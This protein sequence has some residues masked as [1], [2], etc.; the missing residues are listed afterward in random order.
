MFFYA[1]KKFNN[2][3][4]FNASVIE[5]DESGGMPW[6]LRLTY[7]SEKGERAFGFG[8][9]YTR[10]ELTGA[11]IPIF[12]REKGTGRGLEPITFLDNLATPGEGGS[13]DF[14]YSNVP[15]Y[16]TNRAR[17][18]RLNTFYPSTFDL[19]KLPP[20]GPHY[21][22]K[23]ENVPVFVTVNT[24]LPIEGSIFYGQNPLDIISEYTNLVG[25]M[26]PLP[27]WFHSGAIVGVENGTEHV[28]SAVNMLMKLNET[29]R[30]PIAAAWIQDWT[31]SRRF[32]DRTGLWWNWELDSESEYAGWNDMLRNFSRNGIRV[33][34]YVNPM[35]A[36]YSAYSGRN[37]KFLDQWQLADDNFGGF[38]SAIWGGEARARRINVPSYK[39]NYFE[40][41]ESKGYFVRKRDG[42]IW[43]G[44]NSAA[45]VD[46]TNPNAK[47]WMENIIIKE[48]LGKGG[49]SA[50]MADFGEALPLDAI[51]YDK[52][53]DAVAAHNEYPCLWQETVV[54]ALKRSKVKDVVPFYRSACAYS[55]SLA[56][57]FWSGDQL[58]DW[59]AQDGIKSALIAVLSGGFSGFSLNHI[60][61]GGY[62]TIK[63]PLL[64]VDY[65][66]TKELF[67]RWCEIG[68]FNVVY[69]S[70]PGSEPSK[71]WQ[72]YSD[73]ESII[74]F[75]RFAKVHRAWKFLRLQL[76]QEAHQ[77][78]WPVMRAMF[79]TFPHDENTFA[80]NEQ[81]MLGDDILV[82]PV[83]TNG[84]RIVSVYL[85]SGCWVNVWKGSIYESNGEKVTIKAPLGEPG[86]FG[87]CKSQNLS[88][89]I[90]N[91]REEGIL[92]ENPVSS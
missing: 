62:T 24:T 86:L 37:Q 15:F 87:K 25:R 66:R 83:M 26:K 92:H 22:T 84:A 30:P 56:S 77:H 64:Q 55:P 39:T 90:E 40:E 50:F 17:A 5:V 42:T 76:M 14:S 3:L 52:T 51:L 36:N 57:L 88:Q 12:T 60:D 31:G 9:Q 85:P 6:R 91:L 35:F 27:E 32:P 29:S 49:A 67:F 13:W 89:L 20:Y 72:F 23:E 63:M 7:A 33:A 16:F 59:S 80:L 82:A 43:L 10:M 47:L 58:I 53:K 18:F 70:H 71:D 2:I 81:F 48:V 75:S 74:H 54:N 19:S 73:E 44:Y 79:L 41:G 4:S 11:K 1:N 68:A 28:E 65:T 45:L 21:L 46:L 69:R 61:I 78:G 38:N 34:T 8:M